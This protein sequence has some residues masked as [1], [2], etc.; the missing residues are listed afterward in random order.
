MYTSLPRINPGLPR[1]VVPPGLPASPP[2]AFRPHMG[3]FIK[4]P[5]QWH[6]WLGAASGGAT[7]CYWQGRLG[8][9]REGALYSNNANMAWIICRQ[10]ETMGS[11]AWAAYCDGRVYLTQRRHPLLGFI[12]IATK[13]RVP[14]ARRK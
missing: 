8:A 11:L 4:T 9:A 13:S 7:C 12:Y 14:R 5:E 1:L 2:R 10:A 6:R 3:P